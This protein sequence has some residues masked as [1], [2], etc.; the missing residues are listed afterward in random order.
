MLD[1]LAAEL[2]NVV[3]CDVRRLITNRADLEDN[4]RHYPR[5]V[6]MQMA[7]A[8]RDSVGTEL[9]EVDTRVFVYRS[10][11]LV[12]RLLRGGTRRAKRLAAKVRDSR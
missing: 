4:I 11:H 9:V 12:R 7:E 5:R 1:G 2:D 6:H 10:R 3:V 8:I